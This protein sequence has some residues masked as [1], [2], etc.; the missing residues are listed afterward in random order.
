MSHACTMYF[1]IKT[2]TAKAPVAKPMH[3][4]IWK[5]SA[6]DT[7]PG[8]AATGPT[9]SLTI[10]VSEALAKG[11]IMGKDLSYDVYAITT[12]GKSLAQVK[13]MLSDPTFTWKDD[14]LTLSLHS[15]TVTPSEEV[16]PDPFCRP[17]A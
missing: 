4:V 13:A 3:T 9:K 12:P 17:T 16:V 10:D 1:F 15:V 14:A 6:P 2:F 7:G 5:L 11:G 8:A